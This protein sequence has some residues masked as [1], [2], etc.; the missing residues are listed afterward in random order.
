[1]ADLIEL[2]GFAADNS[3]REDRVADALAWFSLALPE[4]QSLP[5][6]ERFSALMWLLSDEQLRLNRW[7]R[8]RPETQAK[9]RAA[10]TQLLEEDR[11]A[12]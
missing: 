10:I 1:M 9:L 12:A 4:V 5:G 3:L 6:G 7:A 11:M 8:L 2:A